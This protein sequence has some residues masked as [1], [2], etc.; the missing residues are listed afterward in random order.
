[1]FTTPIHTNTENFKVTILTIITIISLSGGLI[2][3][4]ITGCP[5]YTTDKTLFCTNKNYNFGDKLLIQ[6][7][8][9]DITV[10]SKVDA[11]NIDWQN[12]QFITN[13]VVL[14]QYNNFLDNAYWTANGMYTTDNFGITELNKNYTI[15]YGPEYFGI[16]YNGGSNMLILFINETQSNIIYDQNI[17]Q[18]F[19]NDVAIIIENSFIPEYKCSICFKENGFSASTLTVFITALFSILGQIYKTVQVPISPKIIK[20]NDDTLLSNYD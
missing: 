7:N 15:L 14:K 11:N 12:C 4:T 6:G 3:V 20:L 19:T 10:M 13:S 2:Y 9:L 16:W 8:S 17:G 18:A 5:Y 1:M